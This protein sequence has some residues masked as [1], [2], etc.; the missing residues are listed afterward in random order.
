MMHICNSFL[1]SPLLSIVF[2]KYH[3]Y[4]HCLHYRRCVALNAKRIFGI[5]WE[6]SS[7][8]KIL[9][10]SPRLG[11]I[12]RKKIQNCEIGESLLLCNN[13]AHISLIKNQREKNGIMR[14]ATANRRAERQQK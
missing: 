5:F 2:M 4:F 13:D 7:D 10:Y 3:I 11:E 8:S 12:Q 9:L 6:I 14:E 1:S